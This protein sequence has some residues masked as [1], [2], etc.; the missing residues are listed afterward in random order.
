[1][2]WHG[3]LIRSRGSAPRGGLP[4]QVPGVPSGWSPQGPS[5]SR[6]VAGRN[7]SIG[8]P[9]SR[10]N[11][12]APAYPQ[13]PGPQGPEGGPPRQLDEEAG[14]AVPASEPLGQQLLAEGKM[15]MK[16]GRAARVAGDFASAEDLLKQA[17]LVF[18]EAAAALPDSIALLGTGETRCWR[19]GSSRRDQLEAMMGGPPPSSPAAE[20]AEAKLEA[21]LREEAEN[22]LL[23]AGTKYRAVAERDPQDSR[24]L[25]NWS[26]AMATRAQ[27][28]L[29]VAAARRLYVSAAAKL[30]A[31][32]KAE[33]NNIPAQRTLGLTLHALGTLQPGS[34]TPQDRTFLQEAAWYLAPLVE[35]N[36]GDQEA[37]NALRQI[38]VLLP[39]F[40]DPRD[41]EDP[42]WEA[43]G[44]GSYQ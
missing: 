21:A 20:A 17:V 22:V 8:P 24:A 26:R 6:V 19:W 33:P 13:S 38:N 25:W 30:E 10:G 44:M 42:S 5:S 3:R 18:Q 9:T 7:S 12:F 2:S 27:L 15:L 1:M 31:V 14:L 40:P 4:R 41:V 43:N 16:E 29:D 11:A 35:A 39:S 36:P 32:L 28:A 37:G 34:R 23:E